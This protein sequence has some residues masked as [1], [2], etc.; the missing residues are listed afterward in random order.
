MRVFAWYVALWDDGTIV[1]QHSTQGI[2]IDCLGCVCMYAERGAR[3]CFQN[4]YLYFTAVSPSPSRRS[5]GRTRSSITHMFTRGG[6]IRTGHLPHPATNGRRKVLGSSHGVGSVGGRG[7][8][9]QD[10]RAA[11]RG[12][13]TVLV[14][15]VHTRQGLGAFH[16]SGRGLP[17]GRR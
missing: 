8:G 3:G 2:K 4:A 5:I 16:Y 9:G 1:F 14:A 11:R 10:L 12:G 13:R 15:V 7:S 17:T 6:K